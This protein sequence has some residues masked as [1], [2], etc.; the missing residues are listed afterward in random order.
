[1]CHEGETIAT[2]YYLEKPGKLAI[3]YASFLS[4]HW[5]FEK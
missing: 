2:N 3:I 5:L 1:M 4:N